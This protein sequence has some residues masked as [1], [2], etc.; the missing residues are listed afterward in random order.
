MVGH[1]I[2]YKKASIN[3]P[4][5]SDFNSKEKN[6]DQTDRSGKSVDRDVTSK[7]KRAKQNANEL[8][9]SLTIRSA[10]EMMERFYAA[11]KQSTFFFLTKR[12]KTLPPRQS[13]MKVS[14]TCFVQLGEGAEQKHGQQGSELGNLTSTTNR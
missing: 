7:N 10:S 13:L 14:E 5:A 12:M 8:H 3:I 9:V 4:G 1:C 11:E 6:A 2:V